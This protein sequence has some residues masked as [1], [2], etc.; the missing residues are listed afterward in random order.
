MCRMIA[1]HPSGY[2]ASLATPVSAR[3]RENQRLLGLIKQ[4]WPE[5]GGVYGYRKI[6]DDLCGLGK[7]CGKHRANWCATKIV[8]QTGYCRRRGQRYGQPPVVPQ[9]HLHRAHEG[10]LYL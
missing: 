9:H 10:W 5:S 1:V 8:F 7:C 2:Y 3:Q 6:T 4:S